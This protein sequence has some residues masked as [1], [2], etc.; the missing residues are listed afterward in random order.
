ME[1]NFDQVRCDKTRPACQNCQRLED[2]CVYET[3]TDGGGVSVES[4]REL[5]ERIEKLEHLVQGLSLASVTNPSKP[6]LPHDRSNASSGLSSQ[7]AS[8]VDQESHGI[9][10]FEPGVC[11]YMHPGYWINPSELHDEP[12][13]LLRA[14]AGDEM[15]WPSAPIAPTIPGPT[16]DELATLHLPVDQEDILIDWY[17]KHVE[18]FTKCS[19]VQAGKNEISMFRIGRSIIPREIEAGIFAMQALT[20]AAMPSSLVQ[21]LL[22]QS[23]RGMIKHFQYATER[24][25]AKANL[26]RTR[27]HYL[28]SAFLHYI[29][30]Q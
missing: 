3:L 27:N 23:R 15:I 5:Q 13:E 18:P 7:D 4:Q 10:V 20:V 2:S 22:G 12:R 1:L 24:A 25:L 30:S 17:A 9:V 8:R 28:L 19:H 26:M 6:S 16:V 21:A 11:Y 29:V 14:P